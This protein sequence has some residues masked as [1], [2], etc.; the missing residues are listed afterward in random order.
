[1][2]HWFYWWKQSTSYYYCYFGGPNSR[3]LGL[4]ETK[5]PWCFVPFFSSLR[6][7]D[8][9][10][11]YVYDY[12]LCIWPLKGYGLHSSW[13]VCVSVDCMCLAWLLIADVCTCGRVTDHGPCS[14]GDPP[15]LSVQHA[16]LTKGP[17]T[18]SLSIW[19]FR[20]DFA[21]QEDEVCPRVHGWFNL[22]AF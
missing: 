21:S 7:Q 20:T 18:V 10:L 19:S 3:K 13:L 12:L 4:Y 1:M 16:S 14:Q 15:S 6:S 8:L 5:I 22:L 11:T 17:R 9:R 2:L